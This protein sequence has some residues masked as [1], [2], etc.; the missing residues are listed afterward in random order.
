MMEIEIRGLKEKIES[1]SV[2]EKETELERKKAES[3]QKQIKDLDRE[4]EKLRKEITGENLVTEHQKT[5]EEIEIKKQ[6]LKD[7]RREK[8]SDL[9]SSLFSLF[10]SNKS[11]SEK[12]SKNKSKIKEIEE[13]ILRLERKNIVIEND[14]EA[15]NIVTKAPLT[16]A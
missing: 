15:S 16:P 10:S 3:K 6:E 13:E 8:S 1:I 14:L 2:G 7:L 11:E 4:I 9:T 12:E 5:Q